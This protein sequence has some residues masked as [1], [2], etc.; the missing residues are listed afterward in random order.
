M[1]SKVSILLPLFL[2]TSSLAIAQEPATQPAPHRENIEW[3]DVWIPDTNAATPL[4]RILLIG[5]SITKEYGPLVEKNLK[6]KA[7]VA[8]LTTSKSLGDPA[9]LSE[10]ALVLSEQQFDII[11]FNNG[12]HGHDY[13]ED[14]YAAA[15]PDLLALLRKAAP[16]AQLIAAT[17]TPTRQANHLDQV[18]DYTP[19][20][21]ARNQAL[22]TLCTQENIPID[23]LFSIINNHPDYFKP[24]GVHHLQKGIDAEAQDVTARLT[25]LL[26]KFASK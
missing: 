1:T 15:L 18:G 3:L 19:R 2:L 12:M 26:H 14:Q 21:I 20:V 10:I 25:D 11:H 22:T 4:P 13:T 23:D 7:Y 16:A 6:G 17:T 24:D 8:R 9:L 5:D